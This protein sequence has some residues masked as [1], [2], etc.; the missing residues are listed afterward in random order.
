MPIQKAIGFSMNTYQ[1]GDSP[2]EISAACRSFAP[3]QNRPGI[4]I[5]MCEPV[6]VSSRRKCYP[7]V[8]DLELK[9]KRIEIVRCGNIYHYAL[10]SLF[11]FS[12]AKRSVND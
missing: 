11:V 5:L 10:Y 7:V 1:I 4:T 9:K 12:L 8:T 6:S 2:L 3:L